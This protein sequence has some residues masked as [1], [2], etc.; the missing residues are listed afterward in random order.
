MRSR[1]KAVTAG[2]KIRALE[3]DAFAGW[4]NTEGMNYI[5]AE[6]KLRAAGFTNISSVPLGDLVTGILKKPGTIDEITIG[7]EEPDMGERYYPTERIVISYHS[8]K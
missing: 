4:I 3:N 1:N 5:V 8:M 6:E 2:K 7:G